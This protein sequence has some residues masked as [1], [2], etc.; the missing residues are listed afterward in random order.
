MSLL[1]PNPSIFDNPLYTAAATA[2]VLWILPSSH[3]HPLPFNPPVR[4]TNPKE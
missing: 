1:H 4:E 2:A 3:P